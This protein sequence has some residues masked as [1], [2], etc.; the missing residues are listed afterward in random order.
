MTS[1]IKKDTILI[2][3]QD[4]G[5]YNSIHQLL[6][7]AYSCHWS[8]DVTEAMHFMAFRVPDLIIA[9]TNESEST[10]IDLLKIIRKS[11]KT[12]LIPFIIL[13]ASNHSKL[14]IQAFES[15][16]D[17]SI[18]Y[19]FHGD[20]LKA[21]VKSSLKKFKEFYLLTITDE[22]TRLYN[23]R[24]FIKK[25]NDEI[26]RDHDNTIS[27]GILDIDFFKQVNDLY[28]HQTG[29]VVLMKLADLLQENTSETFFPA[30]FGGEEFVIL[31][32]D[33][34]I[35]DARKKMKELLVSFSHIEF[36]KSKKIF[37]VTFSSGIAEY[38]G[39]ARTISELLSRADQ[40]L[41]AAKKDGRNRIYTFSPI[42]GHNDQFWEYMRTKQGLFTDIHSNDAI[43]GLPFLPQLLEIVSDLD[44][45]I[46]SIGV[47]ILS[48]DVHYDIEEFS[49]LKNITYDLESVK[50]LIIKSCE[51]IFP[52]DTYVG[53]SDIYTYEFIVMFPSAVDFSFNRNKFNAICKE[54][55]S[56]I[57]NDLIRYNFNLSWSSGVLALDSSNTRKIIDEIA[58]IRKCTR[59]FS[60]KDD[61]KSLELLFKQENIR[62]LYKN[63]K[64]NNF[65]HTKSL[66]QA[67]SF[68]SF[69]EPFDNN[70]IFETLTSQIINNREKLKK[71]LTAILPHFSIESAIPMILPCLQGI[72]F[73]EFIDTLHEVIPD[74]K[75]LV[76]INEYHLRHV[77]FN[78]YDHFF[79]ELPDTIS[80]GLD[81][82]Y[83]GKEILNL[84]SRFNFSLLVFSENITRNIYHFKDRIKIISGLKIF[85]D[86]IGVETGVKGIIQEEEYQIIKDLG[87]NFTAGPLFK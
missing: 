44:F 75:L 66:K 39:M 4:N 47:L 72:K 11:I 81:N 61:I 52:S 57:N 27:L 18:A 19:P 54:I 50:L 29:D 15:G 70:C 51:L 13:T 53:L 8:K 71:F 5:I 43:T 49:G 46:K 34:Q 59:P 30:R 17:G 83:I 41:Y 10:S 68:F 1:A 67:F 14:R 79:N 22:L 73:Q 58:E 82:C 84:L 7:R 86:Q 21:L 28:G 31:F 32:P 24:E 16:A 42:M 56:K 33:T 62:D 64:K 78:E 55:C 40:A 38:P 9:E 85:L 63:V 80:V 12:K 60:E 3:T 77:V 23:R 35:E 6:K 2:V 65:Y 36:K 76:M 87:I 37:R 26:D 45:E 48:L 69:T 74:Q 25:F 20:E